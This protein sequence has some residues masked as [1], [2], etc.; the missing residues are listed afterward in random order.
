MP[1]ILYSLAVNV[2]LLWFCIYL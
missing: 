1:Q 2:T